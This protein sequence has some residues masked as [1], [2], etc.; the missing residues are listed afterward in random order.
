[1]VVAES[2]SGSEFESE[3]VVESMSIALE[4]CDVRIPRNRSRNSRSA[5]ESSSSASA[6]G[7]RLLF[8]DGRLDAESSS[9]LWLSSSSSS[10]TSSVS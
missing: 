8:D 2:E 6:T 10:S 1:V 5:S 7:P 3:E 9:S 4:C